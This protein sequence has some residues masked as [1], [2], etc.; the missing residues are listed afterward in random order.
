M[1]L[2]PVWQHEVR[3]RREPERKLQDWGPA[4]TVHPGQGDTDD[5]RDCQVKEVLE[6]DVERACDGEILIGAT[7]LGTEAG[8]AVDEDTPPREGSEEVRG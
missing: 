3:E 4:I 2:K 1:T 7:F 6:T 8:T 5:D